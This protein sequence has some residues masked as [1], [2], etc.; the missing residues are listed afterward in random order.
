MSADRMGAERVGRHRVVVALAAVL[1]AVASLATSCAANPT[2]SPRPTH[3]GALAAVAPAVARGTTPPGW[4]PVDFGDAQVSVPADWGLVSNGE[5]ACLQAAGAVILGNG[6]WCPPT[7]AD[8]GSPSPRTVSLRTI[9]PRPPD[10]YGSPSLVVDGIPVYTPGVAP[11]YEIPLLHVSLSFTGDVP[12]QV[13]ASLTYSPRAVV[14]APDG[15]TAVPPGWRRVRFAG[16]RLAVPP[17]W[18]VRRQTTSDSCGGP[19]NNREPGAPRVGDT[20]LR[21]LPGTTARPAIGAGRARSRDRQLRPGCRPRTGL[22]PGVAASA[23]PDRLHRHGRI[24]Q[25]PRGGRVGSERDGPVLPR[26]D[27]RRTRRSDRLPFAASVMRGA[28]C[29]FPGVGPGLRA[30]R[31]P[32]PG[33]D[34]RPGPRHPPDPRTA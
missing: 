10:G 1:A 6:S 27:R 33:G 15:P 29:P 17:T 34:R 16:I 30:R 7:V 28:G 3:V 18:T 32:A 22:V 20:R 26:V 31:L 14:L 23:G 24:G 2:S 5:S 4:L 11:V 12:Q 9:G 13:L 8:A 19:P 25:H 21:L